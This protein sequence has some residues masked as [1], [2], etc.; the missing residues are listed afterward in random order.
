M[1]ER[2]ETMNK[3]DQPLKFT[4]SRD[5]EPLCGDLIKRAVEMAHAGLLRAARDMDGSVTMTFEP[6]KI[7]F[8]Y[9]PRPQSERVER[10]VEAMS[11]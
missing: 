2:A 1:N 3:N 6:Q 5:E 10:A 8:E 7:A 4:I 11:Q 9:V